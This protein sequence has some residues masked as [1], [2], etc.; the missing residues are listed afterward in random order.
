MSLSS[1]LKLILLMMVSLSL[2]LY[3]LIRDIE[4][5]ARSQN[6]FNIESVSH[7]VS[8][9]FINHGSLKHEE[10]LINIL[11]S[12]A[13]KQRSTGV[14]GD[15]FVIRS[16]DF[17]ILWDSSIDCRVDNIKM[18]LTEDGICSLFQNPQS[19]IDAARKMKNRTHFNTLTWQFDDSIEWIS[20]KY[21]NFKIDGI[22]Y[23]IAQG[24]QRDEAIENF[25][26]SFIALYM[27]SIIY[28]ITISI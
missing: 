27:L 24:S 14:T 4:Y 22:E 20:Y 10:N 18:F 5:T 9:E 26:V 23:I 17:N 28:I 21:F 1:K 25:R 2:V 6:R 3:I 15:I 12:C 11:D 16:I 7:C 8:S 13:T 19:C